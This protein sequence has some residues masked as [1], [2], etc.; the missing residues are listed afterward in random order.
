MRLHHKITLSTLLGTVSAAVVP[1]QTALAQITNPAIGTELGGNPD[2][3][4]SGSTFLNYFVTLWRGVMFIGAL[5]V[6]VFFIWGG[7]EW[8]TAGGDAGKV[9]KA[10]DKITQAVIGLILLVA[11]F[12]I[13]GFI[14]AVF[15]GDQFSILNPVIPTP[16]DAGSGGGGG[17][18]II[19]IIN[20]ILGR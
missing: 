20:G 17:G 12:T 6:I 14:S 1:V 10:R 15:F 2:A 7:I 18:G 3:A 19:D 8:I 5:L 11:S 9:G 4:A 13:I 16:G